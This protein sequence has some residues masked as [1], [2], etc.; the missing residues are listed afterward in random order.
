MDN[1]WLALRRHTGQIVFQLLDV[2]RG[3]TNVTCRHHIIKTC[4]PSQY[5]Q[6]V[7]VPR[8]VVRPVVRPVALQALQAAVPVAL[9]PVVPLLHILHIK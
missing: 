1:V 7:L 8:Q 9:H 6:S 5:N 3:S 2:V 4:Q